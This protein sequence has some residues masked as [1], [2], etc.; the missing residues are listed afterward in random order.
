M[1]TISLALVLDLIIFGFLL[2]YFLKIKLFF[3]ERIAWGGVLGFVFLGIIM[4]LSGYFFNLG[5]LSLGIFLIAVNL[6][7]VFFLNQQNTRFIIEDFLDFKSRCKQYVWQIFFLVN[8][9]FIL[10]FGYLESQLL[11]FKNGSFFVQPVHSYGDISQHLGIISSFAYGNNF[12][13][14]SS[15]LSGTK[16]SYP[17]LM[18][19]ITAIFVNPVSLRFDQAVSLTGVMMMGFSVIILSFFVLK[20][21]RSKLSAILVLFLFFFSGGL[22]FV[23]F[24]TDFQNSGV[25]FLDFFTHLSRDYTA[26]KDL[27]Y[28][29]INVVLMM[30]LPQRSFLLGL[31]L[32]LII[33]SIFWDLSVHFDIKKFV[34]AVIL[35]GLLPLIHAHSLIAISPF[36]IWLTLITLKR[37][38]YK[39][40]LILLIGFFGFLIM[41]FL[42]NTYL[43]QTVSIKNFFT[44]QVGWMAHEES[45][46]EFYFKNFGPILILIPVSLYIGWKHNI[47]LSFLVLIAQIW[48]IL[49]SIFLFQPWEFDNTKLFIYW[50]LFSII[51]VAYIFRESLYSNK[52]YLIVS[53]II[54]LFLMTFSGFLDMSR[55]IFSSGT[56]YEVYSPQAIRVAQF[57]IKNTH[58]NAVFLSVDKFDNPVVALAG[59]KTVVGYHGW[60]W[61]YGLDYSKRDED[62]RLMLAGEGS[63]DLFRK[64][65]IT[66]VILF[67]DQTDYKINVDYFSKNFKLIYDKEE[68]KIYQ[69]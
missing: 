15:I 40:R 26:L 3:E 35:T 25:N 10:V 16:I 24:F 33:I 66:D 47:K 55:L 37:N 30:F 39:S 19:F 28:F 14:Q 58:K 38:P 44:I 12:P 1:F 50:Y 56:R 63:P 23:Y 31:P 43:G 51:L 34:F 64:Y 18:D 41:L 48:F 32:A 20:I 57:T 13:L 5:V 69:I 4:L 2:T 17:F 6:I 65:N 52:T 29:W 42:S 46:L 59:R 68:Y 7:S 60:L 62:I 9:G 53:T 54:L 8:L 67:S 11:I 36:L 21:T 22:G 45:I 27:N 49:P 61:T